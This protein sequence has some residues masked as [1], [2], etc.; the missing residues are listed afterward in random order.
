MI[1]KQGAE[2]VYEDLSKSLEPSLGAGCMWAL[3]SKGKN[4]I[5]G[6]LTVGIGTRI[7]SPWLV[8]VITGRGLLEGEIRPSNR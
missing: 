1:D 3:S 8:I 6:V 5:S 4:V 7:A 2:G